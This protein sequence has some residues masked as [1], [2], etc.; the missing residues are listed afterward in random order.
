MLGPSIWCDEPKAPRSS[1]GIHLVFGRLQLATKASHAC[2][3]IIEEVQCQFPAMIWFQFR[4][5]LSALSNTLV[6]SASSCPP[7]RRAFKASNLAE[8]AFLPPSSHSSVLTIVQR[9]LLIIGG[10][11][12]AKGGPVYSRALGVFFFF[13]AVKRVGSQTLKW[14][15]AATRLPGTLSSI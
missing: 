4:S 10:M 15:M 1:L 2:H 14:S 11:S 8:K 5:I 6:V 12:I 13:A 7:R 9:N 3:E